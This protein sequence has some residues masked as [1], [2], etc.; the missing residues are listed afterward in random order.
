M[1]HNYFVYILTNKYKKVLYVGVTND[2]R[3]RLFQ[4]YEDS[5][6]I[7]K[8]FAG[9]YNCYHLV[10]WERHQWIQHAID[11][12]KEIKGWKRFRKDDLINE[13]NPDWKFLNDEID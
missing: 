11:R 9:K 5:I 2:L 13:F 7:K 1:Q 4:H 8:T 6:G 10:Y 3:T 12:E